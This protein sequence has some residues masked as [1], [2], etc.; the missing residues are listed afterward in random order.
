[1]DKYIEI[2]NANG[3]LVIDDQYNIPKF[4]YR[5]F[6]YSTTTSFKPSTLWDGDTFKYRGEVPFK[7]VVV[8]FNVPSDLG[9]NL[10]DES[11]SYS[12]ILRSMLVFS[13]SSDQKPYTF[14]VAF[15]MNDES[16]SNQYR[17]ALWAYVTSDVPN[18]EIEFCLYTSLPMIPCK[19][20]AQAFNK[21]GELIF[22]AMRGYLQVIGNMYGGVNVK[23]NPCA[24]Y[25]IDVPV[26]LNP[27]NIFFS[28]RSTLPF[29]SAYNIGANGVKYGETFFF[30]KPRME[31]N[32][33]LIVELFAQYNVSGNNSAKSYNNYY[34]NVIYCPYPSGV[35]ITGN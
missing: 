10:P 30:P 23:N 25:R 17:R 28:N 11:P 19:M 34:E 9:F 5:G 15:R 35:W 32:N 6:A 26:G 22:D 14:Y 18:Q 13:K 12:L 21:H 33:R 3:N 2:K 8:K 4:L 1:V 16:D 20:G 27:D 29:Y 24:V 7:K 31:G